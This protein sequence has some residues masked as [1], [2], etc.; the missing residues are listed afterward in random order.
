[1]TELQ[2]IT[3][4]A[5]EAE[6]ADMLQWGE[7]YQRANDACELRW[8]DHRNAEEQ[9]QRDAAAEAARVAAL[10]GQVNFFRDASASFDA[11]TVN[12]TEEQQAWM[13]D[14]Y[15]RMRVYS[16]YFDTRTSWFP[17]GIVYQ[18]AYAQ[19][20]NAGLTPWVLRDAAGSP[21]YIPYGAKPY[22]Q[23]AGDITNP[24]FRA[25]WIAKARTKLAQGYRGLFVDDV[26]YYRRLVRA[27]GTI[28]TSSPCHAGTL[29]DALWRVSM[30]LFMAEIRQALPDTEITHNVIWQVPETPEVAFGLQQ[31]DYVEKELGVNDAGITGGT[32]RFSLRALLDWVDRRHAA[33]VGVIWD[34][35]AKT[36]DERQ[37]GLACYLLTSNGNDMLGTRLG[38]TPADWWT[39]YDIDLGRPL[40][41][42]E[43][44][45]RDFE[46]G[47]VVV[48]EPGVTPGTG[49][50]F[51]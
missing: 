26:N 1:M 24:A 8:N 37:Y 36:D 48:K 29:T 34:S 27:D 31:C 38:G 30:A 2:E 21:L 41:P 45:T 22:A 9:A 39:G 5:L 4:A 40:G 43:G 23:Y 7:S 12:P 25:D 18:D 28:P 46:H 42:R 19:Y 15:H 6:R 47:G 17:D 32:G 10:P 50:V 33:G 13:R 3:N 11:F 35:L 49:L 20:V 44:L 51:A 14:H 16:P